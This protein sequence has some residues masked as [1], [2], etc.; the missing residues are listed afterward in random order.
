EAL[1]EQADAAKARIEAHLRSYAARDGH[2]PRRQHRFLFV[3][4]AAVAASITLLV[5]AAVYFTSN[6]PSS[7]EATAANPATQYEVVENDSNNYERIFLH[8][9]T[10]VRLLPQG[11]VRY[12][13]DD[14]S[15][16]RELYLEGDA[17]FDI[18]PNR[19]RPFYV[20]AGGVV[21][22]VVGTSFIIRARGEEPEVT[23][24]VK[25]GKVTVYSRSAAY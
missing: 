9:G 7:P 18:A 8:D 25:T 22:R 21:T 14:H 1:E 17:Y 19:E 5:A 23:V 10:I 24:A 3:R 2:H 20:Y 4:Y 13:A 11:R 16:S 6:V 15:P 12:N